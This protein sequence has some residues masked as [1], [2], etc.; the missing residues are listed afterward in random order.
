MWGPIGPR[1][2][3]HYL[4]LP[5]WNRLFAF[6]YIS[7][8]TLFTWHIIWMRIRK[9]PLQ[10]P[11]ATLLSYKQ[12]MK[13]P[14]E[15][16]EQDIQYPTTFLIFVIESQTLCLYPCFQSQGSQF[17][18]LIRNWKKFKVFDKWLHCNYLLGSDWTPTHIWLY[19]CHL[20]VELENTIWNE[21]TIDS[22][23]KS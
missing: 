20:S 1:T 16:N 4:H 21:I 8:L 12:K 18:H 10:H 22:L 7:N 19:G 15:P 5:K 11:W 2:K 6:T 23:T 17:L 13:W 3:I 14:S 9:V